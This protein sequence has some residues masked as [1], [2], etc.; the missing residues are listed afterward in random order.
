MI[1]DHNDLIMTIDMADMAHTFEF[2]LRFLSCVTV[3]VSP[4]QIII[5]FID[6]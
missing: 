5:I 3:T 6:V 1:I 4:N 2:V